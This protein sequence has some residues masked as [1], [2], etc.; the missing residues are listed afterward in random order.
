MVQ[1]Q[2]G[3]EGGFKQAWH[4]AGKYKEGTDKGRSPVACKTSVRSQLSEEGREGPAKA[5][6]GW[7]VLE[8]PKDSWSWATGGKGLE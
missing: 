4:V 1:A 7:E 6:D 8:R 3:R 5:G 2:S